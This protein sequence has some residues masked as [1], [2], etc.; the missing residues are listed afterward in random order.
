QQERRFYAE[1]IKTAAN[2]RTAS[3]VEAYVPRE[4][5]LPPGPWLIRSEIDYGGGPPQQPDDDPRHVYHNVVI[6][7]DPARQLFNGAPS[8]LCMCI[9]ALGLTPGARAL[10]LRSPPGYY[11]A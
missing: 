8:L 7:I 4:K 5:F 11:P 3:L 2:L 6:A 10:H 9:D 1:E